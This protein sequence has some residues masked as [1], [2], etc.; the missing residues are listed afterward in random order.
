MTCDRTSLLRDPAIAGAELPSSQTQPVRNLRRRTLAIV[1]AQL[2]MALAAIGGAS[3]A[4]AAGSD[5]ASIVLGDGPVGY[6]RGGDPAGSSTMVDSSTA[7]NNLAVHSGV[8]FGQTGALANDPDTAVAFDGTTSGYADNPSTVPASLALSGPVSMEVWT[9]FTTLPGHFVDLV[10]AGD[11][12]PYYGMVIDGN[13][14]AS[15]FLWYDGSAWKWVTGPVVPAGGWH[16][17]VMTRDSGLQVRFY[18]DGVLRAGP[19]AT[20]AVNVGGGP[21]AF[22]VGGMSYAEDYSGTLDEVAVYPYQLGDAQV[23]THFASGMGRLTAIARV[24]GGGLA[25]LGGQPALAF[26]SVTRNGSDQ[27]VGTTLPLDVADATGSSA[28]WHITVA[29]SPFDDG[30]GDLLPAGALSA[31]GAGSFA[32]DAMSVCT[33]AMNGQVYPV[34]LGPTPATIVD[35]ASGS[36]SGA[37]SAG[38][39]M[40]LVVPAGARARM[41]SSTWTISLLSG[42]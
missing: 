15:N 14:G 27:V 12:L 21:G 29:A 41:Y 20:T 40:T 16:H 17:L 35:T 7:G 10:R 13:S 9:S 37:Q 38:V 19:L 26:P 25:L 36:G 22:T 5:Y 8:T 24:A 1:G 23:A 6:W 30:A 18:L 3:P 11:N 31:T 33:P 2:L 39:S 32:C 28:G 42:P 4:R 34:P